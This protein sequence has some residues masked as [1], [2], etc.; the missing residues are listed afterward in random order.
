M[1]KPLR[2]SQEWRPE[3]ERHC[4]EPFAGFPSP[5]TDGIKDVQSSISNP[6]SRDSLESAELGTRFNRPIMLQFFR[7]T[8]LG[9]VLGLF[10]RDE[11]IVLEG[12]SL[13]WP[14]P[15][16]EAGAGRR[17]GIP[18]NCIVVADRSKPHRNSQLSNA[19]G[20]FVEKAEQG[21]E[22][23]VVG[24]YGSDD[25]EVCSIHAHRKTFWLTA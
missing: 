7:D 9:Y 18:P 21:A 17:N 13:V 1:R 5:L 24:W 12:N 20:A 22:N 8:G 6:F 11:S 2:T 14:Y 15:R 16:Y 4:A 10:S 3:V 23:C 25:Q 19:D